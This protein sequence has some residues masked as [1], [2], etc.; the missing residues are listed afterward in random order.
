MEVSKVRSD[1][2]ERTFNFARDVR[3]FVKTLPRNISFVA[4]GAQLIRASGSVGA[5]YLEAQE[6]M[7]RK[8]FGLR[9][10][11]SRKEAKESRYWLGLLEGVPTTLANEHQRLYKE[12]TELLKILS[13]IVEKLRN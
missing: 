6:A 11:I 9:I 2:E 7:S 5:N 12:A 3:R 13:A 10:K 8:D 4:D 1:L